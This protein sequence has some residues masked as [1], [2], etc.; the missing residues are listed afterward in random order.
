MVFEQTVIDHLAELSPGQT[1]CSSAHQT[2]E[3]RPE[4]TAKRGTNRATDH[5][6]CGTDSGTTKRTGRTTGG[7]ACETYCATS[8][9]GAIKR[10]DV[11]RV[12]TWALKSHELLLGKNLRKRPRYS[13]RETRV[14][15]K[16]LGRLRE[17]AEIHSV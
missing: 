7:T 14:S 16:S 12:A 1:A 11:N 15:R 10:L 17:N 4:D 8:F 6:N 9:P 13:T 3:D 5:A 2:T